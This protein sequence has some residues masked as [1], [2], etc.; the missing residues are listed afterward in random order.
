M[1]KS[2]EMFDDACHY[3]V[4]VVAETADDD[5][6]HN[7]HNNHDHHDN[8]HHNNVDICGDNNYNRDCDRFATTPGTTLLSQLMLMLLLLLM[9]IFIQIINHFHHDHRSYNHIHKLL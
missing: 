5:H 8:H 3:A 4:S 6:D 9:S 1:V 7:Y 2:F